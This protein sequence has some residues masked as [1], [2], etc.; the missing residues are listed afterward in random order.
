VLEFD[1]TVQAVVEWAADRSD[2]LVVATA[3]H[4]TGG[5]YIL[6]SP[7]QGVVPE[8]SWATGQHTWNPVP[9]FGWNVEHEEAY[10]EVDSTFIYRLTTTGFEPPA[11]TCE[12]D[13]RGSA[14][15]PAG[16]RRVHLPIMTAPE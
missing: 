10:A 13:I 16:N 7:E 1:K 15:P 12:I 6:N 14:V 9:I 5:L 2:V 11:E 4:E 8:A 3:D